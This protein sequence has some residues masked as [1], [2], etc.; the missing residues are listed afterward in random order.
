VRFPAPFA[1]DMTRGLATDQATRGSSRPRVVWAVTGICGVTGGIASANRNVLDALVELAEERDCELCVLSL[2]E[3][4]GDRPADLPARMRF[5]AFS[6]DKRRFT[7]ALFRRVPAR[8]LFCFDHVRLAVPLLPL[9]ATGLARTVIFAHGSEAWKRLRRG[10]RW[11]L[12]CASLCLT[13]SSYTLN[14]MRERIPNIRAAACPLGLAPDF[15]LAPTPPAPDRERF[16]MAAADGIAR[17]LGERVLLAVARMHPDEREKGHYA[18]LAV[19]P[20]LLRAEPGVQMVFAGPGDDRNAIAAKARSLGVG[21]RVFL[22]GYLSATELRRAYARCYAFA[23]PSRQEGF[24]LAYLEAMSFA[25]P[26][27]GCREQGAEEVIADG[28]TGLLVRDPDDAT[29]LLAAL[30]RLLRDP[31]QAER[32]G[33]NGFCRLRQHFTAAHHRARVKERLAPLIG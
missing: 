11:A 6:G 7:A 25:K 22:P 24:G 15:P 29:E 17:N 33:R 10:S 27:L 18:L 5:E 4:S 14:K 20:Q 26:C 23:M 28:E 2:L 16:E 8:G 30:L 31:G 3:T 19:L 1:S 12:S 13:N 32:W 9:A 21:A